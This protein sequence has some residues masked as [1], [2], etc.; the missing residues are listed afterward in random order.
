M[1]FLD[2]A[3][4]AHPQI[5]AARLGVTGGSYGGFMTNWII[6]HTRR[7]QAR[8][9]AALD[10]QLGFQIQHH[11][12]RLLFQ[13]GPDRRHALERRG[14]AVVAFAAFSYADKATT[15]TLVHPFR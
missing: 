7:F 4:A 1:R 14:K 15:P 6:G 8:G 12:H 9:L 10:L 11:G 13:R 5:D 2:A 3:L